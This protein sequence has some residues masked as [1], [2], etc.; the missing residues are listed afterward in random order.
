MLEPGWLTAALAPNGDA[1]Q[2]YRAPPSRHRRLIDANLSR[3]TAPTDLL[4]ATGAFIEA[5]LGSFAHGSDVLI[6]GDI[7]F[8]NVMW[9]DERA[10][11][12]D[13]ETAGAAPR[14][15][16][17]EA[18][19]RFVADPADFFPGRAGDLGGGFMQAPR[20]LCEAYPELWAN[21]DLIGRLEVYDALW[22]LVQLLNHPANH[23]R[24]TIS[25]L[26]AILAGRASWKDLLS[27]AL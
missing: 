22:E 25:R 15:R 20:W 4:A 19:L 8:A 5:R 16:E 6:H 27:G 23:A 26:R 1:S 14:D 7:S 2:A 12:I 10:V 3:E 13:F 17:L 11:L 21:P 9:D 24:G 18:F